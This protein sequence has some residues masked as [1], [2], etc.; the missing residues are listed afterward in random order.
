MKKLGSQ[1]LA[2]LFCMY[3]SGMYQTAYDIL[4]DIVL[5]EQAV[6]NAFMIVSSQ[7][8]KVK[9]IQTVKTQE[10]MYE[11]IVKIAMQQVKAR[12]KEVWLFEFVED[13]SEKQELERKEQF[14][15][16]GVEHLFSE[17]YLRQKQMLLEKVE[18][19]EKESKSILKRIIIKFV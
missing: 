7:L 11:I 19:G 10:Y 4:D 9:N 16:T 6:I 15:N 8:H 12:Q 18:I 5:A 2:A 3:E 17:Q 1:K 14:I 13:A